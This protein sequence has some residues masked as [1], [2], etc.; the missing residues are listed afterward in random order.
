MFM[1]KIISGLL[2][3]VL[4]LCL[5]GCERVPFT[6]RNRAAL[7]PESQLIQLGDQSYREVLQESKTSNDPEKNAMV[8][9]V[10]ARLSMAV[11]S[12][13]SEHNLKDELKLYKWEFNLL[14]NDKVINAFCLPG[15]KVAV[16]TGILPIT[17][18]E[19][20]LAV[21]VGHEIAHAIAQHGNERMSQQLL[22]QLGS[23]V[24]S[25]VIKNN[26]QQTKQIFMAAY[27]VGAELGV[28][29]PYS[30]TQESEADRIGLILMS[31]AGYDVEAAIPFWQRMKEKGGTTPP[32]FLSTHPAPD[33]RI[34]DIK[35]DIPEAK[36]YYQ[37]QQK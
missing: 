14:Q 31:R 27:G 17:E 13:A 18:D 11:E 24:L 26:P 29:L 28:V 37:S 15:G 3:L 33:T 16:Y 5:S 36:T 20:G 32:E 35:K 2:C 12:F 23:V 7:I 22:L 1:Q 10:G 6:G 30:R 8:R 4:L 25:E 21:V 19:T 9:R 34:K